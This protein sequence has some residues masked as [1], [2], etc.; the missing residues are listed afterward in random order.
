MT[1]TAVRPTWLWCS[2]KKATFAL[3]FDETGR[4]VMAAPY[5]HFLRGATYSEVVSKLKG[6]DLIWLGE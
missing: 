3:R 4:V 6:Y 5:A 1:T 2:G